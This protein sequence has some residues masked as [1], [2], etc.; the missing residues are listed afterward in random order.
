MK[1]STSF[2]CRECLAHSLP[3]DVAGL[4]VPSRFYNLLAIGRP[5]VLVSEPGARR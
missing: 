5:V 4:S 2:F 3:Q 1:T